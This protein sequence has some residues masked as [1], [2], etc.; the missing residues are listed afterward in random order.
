M[1]LLE[2]PAEL[3]LHIL[4]YEYPENVKDLLLVCKQFNSL[5]GDLTQIPDQCAFVSCT[6]ARYRGW[7]CHKHSVY[8]VRCWEEDCGNIGDPCFRHGHCCK[9]CGDWCS[10]SQD[11]YFEHT[12]SNPY[13]SEINKEKDMYCTKCNNFCV[14]QH[15]DQIAP[16]GGLCYTCYYNQM[17]I[18]SHKVQGFYHMISP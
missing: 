12:C 11:H 15:C 2:L 7:W 10:K 16:E 1:D 3:I 6:A 8:E 17:M 5:K 4:R 18:P 14:A 9:I 13:C